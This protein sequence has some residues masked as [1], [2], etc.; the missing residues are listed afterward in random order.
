VLLTWEDSRPL[1]VNALVRVEKLH[2]AVVTEAIK[3]GRMGGVATTQRDIV[4]TRDGTPEETIRSVF[5]AVFTR[6]ASN[7]LAQYGTP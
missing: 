6:V 2:K 1:V 4:K 7:P 5:D 3:G